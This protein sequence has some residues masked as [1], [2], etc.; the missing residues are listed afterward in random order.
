[1]FISTVSKYR[2]GRLVVGEIIQDGSI[3]WMGKK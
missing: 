1:M 3:K 2:R